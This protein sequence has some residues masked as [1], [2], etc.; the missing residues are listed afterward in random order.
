MNAQCMR[1]NEYLMEDITRLPDITFLS[2]VITAH[3]HSFGACLFHV[4]R[5][6]TGVRKLALD[7]PGHFDVSISFNF[8]TSNF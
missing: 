7:T 3:A 2:I 6:C 8:F 4:L 1:V 5:M